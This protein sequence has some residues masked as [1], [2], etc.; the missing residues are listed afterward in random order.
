MDKMTLDTLAI[1]VQ[2]G[3]L[4]TAKQSNLL[5][6]EKRVDAL[7]KRMDY[8]FDMIA[9]ELKDIRSRL[10]GADIHAAD[11]LDLQLRVDNIEKKMKT[12]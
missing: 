10:K 1:M 7:E 6:L 8:R 3:F 12:R 2:N 5:A 9:Q 4:E 11:I